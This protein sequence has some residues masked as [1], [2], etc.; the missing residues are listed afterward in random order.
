M[1]ETKFNEALE[2]FNNENYEAAIPKFKE[3]L[4]LDANV[5]LL[6]AQVLQVTPA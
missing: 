5:D 1:L 3:A 2:L 4:A 6:D